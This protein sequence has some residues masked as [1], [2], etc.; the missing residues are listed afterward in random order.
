MTMAAIV[1]AAI[2]FTTAQRAEAGDDAVAKAWKD[3]AEIAAR[4]LAGSKLDLC[5]SAL[6][7]GFLAVKEQKA[8]NPRLY[9]ITVNVSGQIYRAGYSFD[10]DKVASFVQAELPEDWITIQNSNSK[11]LSVV[12]APA[13]C[14]FDLCTTD[15]FANGPCE[16]KS[17]K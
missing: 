13:N 17:Q 4:K 5:D 6:E 2:T 1:A 7:K 12:A 16:A 15:P 9:M 11:T 14:A 8:D 3:R 10:G